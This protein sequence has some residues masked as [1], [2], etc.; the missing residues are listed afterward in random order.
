MQEPLFLPYRAVEGLS[1]SAPA[2]LPG[3]PSH[4]DSGTSSWI[5]LLLLCGALRGGYKGHKLKP[6]DSQ[7]TD[8]GTVCGW[9]VRFHREVPAFSQPLLSMHRVLESK[10]VS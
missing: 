10:E 1:Q 4:W 7:V 3:R 2:G 8:S 6:R 9:A 5:L